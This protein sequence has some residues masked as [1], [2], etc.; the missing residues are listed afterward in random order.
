V[1]R[2]VILDTVSR[3]IFHTVVVFSIYLLASGHNQP[4]G[5]FVGGLVAGAALVLAFATGGV[6]QVQRTVPV[7]STVILGLGL[8]FA[9]LTAAAAWIA[10]GDLLQSAVVDLHLPLFGDVHV[11]TP[12]FF[13]IG[14]YLVVLGLVAKILETIGAEERTTARDPGR[15]RR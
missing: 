1:T 5:G 2:S 15:S 9:Q 10:G 13:D 4:G 8:A 7:P 14:V 6:D 3:T 12:L 11:A